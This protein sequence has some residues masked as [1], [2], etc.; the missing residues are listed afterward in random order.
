MYLFIF[1]GR[2]SLSVLFVYKLLAVFIHGDHLSNLV[3]YLDDGDDGDNDDDHD[4]DDDLTFKWGNIDF[5]LCHSAVQ[6]KSQ[7]G[8]DLNSW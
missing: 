7:S 1:S 5:N 8:W 2:S 6:I 4:D 3:S